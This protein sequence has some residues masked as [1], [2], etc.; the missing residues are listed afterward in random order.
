MMN[1]WVDFVVCDREKIP[2]AIKQ[3]KDF[4]F[5]SRKRRKVQEVVQETIRLYLEIA[6]YAHQ[7]IYNLRTK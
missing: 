2:K 4:R 5:L 3:H 1:A 7:Q 6:S